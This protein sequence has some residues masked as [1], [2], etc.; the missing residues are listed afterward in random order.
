MM[1]DGGID[2]EFLAL[3]MIASWIGALFGVKKN[4]QEN[5]K[6][7]P[8]KKSI[9]KIGKYMS[10]ILPILIYLLFLGSGMNFM[11]AVILTVYLIVIKSLF[12]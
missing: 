6:F 12:A 3:V 5:Q 4:F 11:S 2:L 7:M 1:P 10:L 8:N 9:K